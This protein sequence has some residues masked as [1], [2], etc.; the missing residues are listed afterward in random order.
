M[1]LNL[2][3]MQCV[4][5]VAKY[6]SISRAAQ[7]LYVSQ[8]HL[9]NQIKAAENLLGVD[10]FIRSTKGMVLTEEG[11][12]FVREAQSIL[13]NVKTL[14]QEIQ[15]KPEQSVRGS[16]SMT[17][18]YQ[19]NRKIGRF[20]QEN[21]DKTSFILHVKETNPFQVI[22]DVYSRKFEVGVLHFFDAQK[23]YF[24]NAFQSHALKF[25]KQYEREFLLAMPNSNP[26]INEPVITKEML[27][28]YIVVIYGD[29]ETP[30]ASYETI[31]RLNDVC[32]AKK[33]IYVYDRATAMETLMNT[34]NAF[35]WITGLHDDTLKQYHLT[36]RRCEDI[37]VKNLGYLIYS[38]E[39]KLSKE[40]KKL[41]AEMKKI[42]WT[43]D[44][45]GH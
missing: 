18:S 9:S 33:R 38:S 6:G 36:L 27:R 19:I 8:P 16:I 15:V 44:V 1:D 32:F 24:L 21:M 41:I 17:R 40:A 10:L 39:E 26:M 7:N 5:E 37:H 45:G 23:E 29:Y 20:I 42:D 3:M 28:E 34:P 31:T 35:M 4:V 14:Q 13:S 43:E 11:H 22:K 12:L 30:S 2:F 25:E